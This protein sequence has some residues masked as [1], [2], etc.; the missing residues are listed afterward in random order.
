MVIGWHVVYQGDSGQT[1]KVTLDDEFSMYYVSR[2]CI[3]NQ[4]Q[5]MKPAIS[6]KQSPLGFFP[7]IYVQIT[8][9][10]LLFRSSNIFNNSS[11]ATAKLFAQLMKR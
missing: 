6:H 8:L 10:V 3:Q 11:S 1:W 9:D 5:A 7:H 2:I 4:S